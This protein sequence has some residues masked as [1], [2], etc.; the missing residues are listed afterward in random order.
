MMCRLAAVGQEK[1]LADSL[2]TTARHRSA[3]TP[4]PAVSCIRS[5]GLALSSL[6]RFS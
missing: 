1:T 3:R 2:R 5:A 4:G 6:G